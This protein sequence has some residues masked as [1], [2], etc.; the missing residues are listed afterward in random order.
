MKTFNKFCD[1]MNRIF[2]YAGVLL[3]VI[4]SIACILQV[5]SRYVLG[6][7][8]QGTEE[9]SRYSFIW[10]GFLGSS[11]CVQKWSNASVSFLN[12][13]LK[14]NAKK[15]HSALLNILVFI[16]AAV[17]FWQG[18]KCVKVTAKQT[19]SMLRIPMNYVYAAIPVGS[20][21]MM[22]S[23]LQRLLNLFVKQ[24]ETESEVTQS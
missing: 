20:F 14:G 7:A 11:V 17:L 22:V 12:D 13:S 23:A 2:S 6:H 16:C 21:G 10:L 5:F 18:L 4:I 24:H 15:W 1:G 19:S 8:I 9:I 3:L